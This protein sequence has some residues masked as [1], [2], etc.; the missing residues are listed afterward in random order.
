MTTK[1]LHSALLIA[2]AIL[3]GGCK[4]Q[5]SMAPQPREY[6][7]QSVALSDFPTTSSF[8][9]SVQG[10]Q[11]I[12]IYPQVSGYLHEIKVNEG[13]EVKEGELL[14]V[15]EQAP[16]RAAYNAAVASVEVAQAVVSTA[17]L[18]YKT[19]VALRRKGIISEVEL[20]TVQNTL[21]SAEAQLSMAQA[22]AASAKTNLDFTE[23][24]SPSAGVVGTFPY[25]QGALVSA[26]SPQ[27]LTTISDN[28]TMYVY[29]S[30]SEVQ[31]YNMI[32]RFG[33]HNGVIEGMPE[34]TLKLTNG[35]EYGTK[36]KLESISG[37]LESS[38][39]AASLRAS[40]ANPDKT[41]LSGSTATVIIPHTITD[42]VVIPKAATFDLQGKF[43]VYKVVD[44]AAKSTPVELSTTMNSTQ[45][46]VTSG[47]EVGD[48]I[49]AS[50]AGLVRE[51][52]LVKMPTESA[53]ESETQTKE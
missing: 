21:K 29:F 39:G 44:G 46:V 50:G 38:T 36:G 2:V 14:F 4:G 18:N 8:S 23:I 37:K 22:Q 17:E 51:G 27:S 35:M 6:E 30:M 40:F 3:M 13:Q 47:L 53:P 33:S 1:V 42:A 26:S 28:T 25:R 12:D 9:A 34:L 43:F 5:Q 49:I 45:Y 16:Y 41:L 11:D 7:L 31:I 15:I 52:S 19:S 20:Q 10:Q 32:D 48:I 24:K